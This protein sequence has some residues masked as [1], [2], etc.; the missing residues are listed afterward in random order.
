VVQLVRAE[1]DVLHH[2]LQDQ[3]KL[4]VF[5]DGTVGKP[6]GTTGSFATLVSYAAGGVDLLSETGAHAQAKQ[7]KAKARG[8]GRR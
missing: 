1:I 2:G 3:C 6:R 5:K 4:Q 7:I 8:T